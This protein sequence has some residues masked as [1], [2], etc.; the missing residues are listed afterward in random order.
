MMG[1]FPQIHRAWLTIDSDIY[2]WT[3][4]ETSDIAYYDGLN[5][6]ILCVGLINPK[7]G[8]FHSYIRYLL[9]LSTAAEI[10]VLG[11]TFGPSATGAMDEIQLIADP[12]FTI[13]TD[14]SV[15][16]TIAGTENGRLF[17]GT[18]EGCL[19]EIAYQVLLL[20]IFSRSGF[21]LFVCFN[22]E[23]LHEI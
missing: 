11:V 17:L 23:I 10:V 2:V 18:K 7:P 13:S 16:S 14:G 22:L 8:V 21:V 6:T 15:I 12:V 4:E 1:L 9:V 5:E 3:Y 19:Y 20:H